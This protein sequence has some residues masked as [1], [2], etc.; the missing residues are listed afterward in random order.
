MAAQYLLEV[1]SVKAKQMVGII[2]DLDTQDSIPLYIPH[3]SLAKSMHQM[4]KLIR[5]YNTCVC[6]CVRARACIY[7]P[8]GT[9]TK[10]PLHSHT[11]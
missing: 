11:Q 9:H 3:I 1:F 2:D 5:K 7:E 4:I 10:V 6:V 8:K